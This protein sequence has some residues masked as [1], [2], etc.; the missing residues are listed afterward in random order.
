ML[1]GRVACVYIPGSIV[2]VLRN[3]FMNHRAPRFY[4][5]DIMMLCGSVP[6]RHSTPFVP[7]LGFRRQS[8]CRLNC[9]LPIHQVS[10]LKYNLDHFIAIYVNIDFQCRSVWCPYGKPF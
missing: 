6:C 9:I 7:S 2:A 8:P 4:T 3:Q 5:D 10:V 1:F